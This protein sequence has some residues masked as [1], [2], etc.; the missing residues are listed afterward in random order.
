MS[1]TPERMILHLDMDCFYVSVERLLDPALISRPVA[2]GG[3]PDGRGVVASASYEARKFGVR[4]AMPMSKAVR[5]CP[6]LV[7]VGG[8]L[9]RYGEYSARIAGI[10]EEF[11][12]LVQMASQD[13]A[14]L[15]L[16]GTERL[17]GT[18]LSA[19]HRLRERIVR[20]TGLPCSIGIGTSKM[21]AKIA[22]ALCKPRALLSIPPGSEA[23]FLAPLSIGRMPG[24]GQKSEER[25]REIGIRTIGQ[26]AT[27]EEKLLLR[28]FG[29]KG[30][31]MRLRALGRSSDVVVP[32]EN[33]KS[34]GAEETLDR[35]T[36]DPL[37][38]DQLLASLVE[39][40]ASRLRHQPCMAS[41]IT[42]KYRYTGFET[43]TASETLAV[44]VNDDMQMLAVARRLLA[45]HRN[46]AL[47]IRLLGVTA[48]SLVFGQWEADFLE[49]AGQ[50]KRTRLNEAMDKMRDKHGFG[51]LRRASS[52][53]AE[54]EQSD[55][56]WGKR[57]R[58]GKDEGAT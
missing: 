7:V 3:S 26:L 6:G 5:L 4:S 22:S 20:E 41:C 1:A 49:E 13:E 30:G 35:D 9:S 14:Y 43:H 10:M 40:V 57:A 32:Q 44:P 56:R 52:K 47:S 55:E 50:D 21:V 51:I 11:T 53:G 19:G 27:A 34:I 25:L 45:E 42:V 2:V 29:N 33:P 31:E 58:G 37:E 8:A 28:V 36:T 15:D 12:P 39:R 24:I 23:R 17:W 46:A 54:A 48:S 16:T 38:I 18:A